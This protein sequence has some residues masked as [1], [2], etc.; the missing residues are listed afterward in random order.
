MPGRRDA[1][2]TATYDLNG[3]RTSVDDQFGLREFTFNADDTMAR[4][5]LGPG[6]KTPD[7]E[8]AREVVHTGHGTMRDDG[9]FG[10]SYDGLDPAVDPGRQQQRLRQRAGL[11]LTRFG[12]HLTLPSG[13]EEVP[14]GRPSK[15]PAGCCCLD[16]QQ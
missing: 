9:C 11:E 5:S 7:D 3:N 14:V 1:A 4:H 13:S 6:D 16:G 8:P 2:R 15:Y 12:G 10:Y